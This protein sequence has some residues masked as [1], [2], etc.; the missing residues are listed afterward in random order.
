MTFSKYIVGFL[1]AA[2]LGFWGAQTIIYFYA[3]E[4]GFEPNAGKRRRNLRSAIKVSLWTA[5]VVSM[6]W[7]LQKYILD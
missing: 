1:I 3:S 4:L 6:V 5:L 7:L 2:F